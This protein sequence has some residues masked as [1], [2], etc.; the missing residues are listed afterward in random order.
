MT[1]KSIENARPAAEAADEAAKERL[2]Y[3]ADV[4]AQELSAAREYL[5]S[6]RIGQRILSCAD[7]DR[8]YLARDRN[9]RELYDHFCDENAN[10]R[11]LGSRFDETLLRARMFGVQTFIENLR[12]DTNCRLLLYWHYVRGRSVTFC[13]SII[14]VSRASAFRIRHRALEYAARA[15]RDSQR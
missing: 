6:Y 9:K 14:G 3:S 15:L 7:Y 5:E 12:C 1:D 13:A 8:Q 10:A 11:V 2:R 4:S